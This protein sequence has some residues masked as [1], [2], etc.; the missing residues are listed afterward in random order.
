MSETPTGLPAAGWYPD[1]AGSNRTRWWDGARWTESFSAP[2]A[3]APAPSAPATPWSSVTSTPASS[4]DPY[5]N[6]ATT[7][8]TSPAPYTSAAPYSGAPEALTAPAGTKPYT[9]FIWILALL[10]LV[11]TVNTIIQSANLDEAIDLATRA[12]SSPG[13]A[14]APVLDLASYAISFALFAA[15]ILLIVL[16][17]R[18]LNRAQVPRP[19]HWAWGFFMIIGAPVYMIG[20]S[21]VVRRRT[22]SGLAPMFVNLGIIVLN[23]V[24]GVTIAIITFGAILENTPAL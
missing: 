1:P 4:A 10:P 11:T 9:P 8:S 24:I 12:A 20:R 21:I 13:A 18:A 2:A 14:P 19:F 15:A 22:G 3:P 5:A 6:A 16:D 23:L 17:W 7:P